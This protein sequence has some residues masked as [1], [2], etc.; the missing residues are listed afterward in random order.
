M[1]AKDIERRDLSSL[2]SWKTPLCHILAAS[3]KVSFPE[4]KKI[5]DIIVVLYRKQLHAIYSPADVQ[6]DEKFTKLLYPSIPSD[7]LVEAYSKELKNAFPA[8]IL[9]ATKSP[10]QTSSS[11]S[12]NPLS[13]SHSTPLAD[14]PNISAP[15]PST[16]S[17]VPSVTTKPSARSGPPTFEELALRL[18]RLKQP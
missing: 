17:S 7:E 4:L 2:E 11:S 16:A 6:A 14:P 5:H 12:P 9:K 18:E 10:T 1:Y 8:D 13:S 3:P 15:D